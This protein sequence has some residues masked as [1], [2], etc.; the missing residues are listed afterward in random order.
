MDRWDELAL[1]LEQPD[2]E[3]LRRETAARCLEADDCDECGERPSRCECVCSD[4]AARPRW[5]P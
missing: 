4:P 2:A 3:A 5:M 1:A